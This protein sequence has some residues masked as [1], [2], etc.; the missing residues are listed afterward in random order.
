MGVHMGVNVLED[1][2]HQLYYQYCYGSHH[3][4]SVIGKVLMVAFALCQEVKQ[5][6]VLWI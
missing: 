2:F 5:S 4:H 1:Q 3:F 6:P